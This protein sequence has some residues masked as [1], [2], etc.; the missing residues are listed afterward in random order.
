MEFMYAWYKTKIK[1]L[2]FVSKLK[3]IYSVTDALSHLYTST[4][5]LIDR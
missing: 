5:T 2:K 1:C 3:Y 4:F